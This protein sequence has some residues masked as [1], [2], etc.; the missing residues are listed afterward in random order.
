M[1]IENVLQV[2]DLGVGYGHKKILQ[3]LSLGLK[4]GELTILLGNNGAGKTTLMKVLGGI[5]PLQEGEILFREE[6]L[7]H[8]SR[9]AY[10]R[11]ICYIASDFKLLFDYSV[12]DFVLLGRMVHA[13]LLATP[14]DADYAAAQGALEALGIEAFAQRPITELSTG[15]RQLAVLARALVQNAEVMIL[16]ELT[17]NLDFTNSCKVMEMIRALAQGGKAVLLSLHDP[18]LAL[19]FADRLLLL[20]HGRILG[21]ISRQQENFY[22]EAQRS[23][24]DM[25][26]QRIKIFTFEGKAF[27]GRLDSCQGG[28]Q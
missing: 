22:E 18:N 7:T 6:N 21:E 15:E 3:G 4:A 2:H 26:E 25:Y 23:F 14:K 27:V 9:K 8:L 28:N 16:D 19:E 5:M 24:S 1:A 12:L 17:A 11:K 20:K 10:A 13:A